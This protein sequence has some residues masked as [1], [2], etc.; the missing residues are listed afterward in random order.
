[1]KGTLKRSEQFWECR[2]ANRTIPE[3][4]P[5]ANLLATFFLNEHD[6][7]AEVFAADKGKS[8]WSHEGYAERQERI[9]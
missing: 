6:A 8:R 2:P 5:Y 7:D 9:F 4:S 3:F 1:M